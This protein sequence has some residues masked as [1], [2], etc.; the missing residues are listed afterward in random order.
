MRVSAGKDP[1]TGRYVYVS[2]TVEGGSRIAD[3]AL[4]G[5]AASTK[6][7]HSSA[8][9]EMIVN[10]FLLVREA[11]G[12]GLKTLD[13][14]RTLV[15]NH[16]VPRLGTKRVSTLTTR[17]LDRLYLQMAAE[18]VGMSTIEHIHR[19]VHAV[20]SQAVRWGLVDKNVASL[21]SPPVSRRKVV[22]APSPAELGQILTAAA[23]GS[24]QLEPCSRFV[25]SLAPDVAR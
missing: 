18:G 22:S 23:V 14:Y 17:D 5:L 6:E 13:S 20:L 4:A 10:E 3:K 12:V 21:A 2:K 7:L 24:P 15:K 8:S 19:L 25:P 11:S 1:L 16:I 9:M